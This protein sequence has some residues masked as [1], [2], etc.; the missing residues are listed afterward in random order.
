MIR[1]VRVVSVG[2]VEICIITINEDG[3]RIPGWRISTALR[4]RF[5][6]K[7]GYL[8]VREGVE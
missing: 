3:T 2:A 1:F 6:Q 4:T 8:Y 7:R 5:G